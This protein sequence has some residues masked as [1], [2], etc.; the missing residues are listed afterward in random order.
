MLVEGAGY[1]IIDNNPNVLQ[2]V[3]WLPHLFTLLSGTTT[4]L[5]GGSPLI[6]KGAGFDLVRKEKNQVY[7]CGHRCEVD[8][9]SVTSTQLECKLPQINTAYV[10]DNAYGHLIGQR[11]TNAILFK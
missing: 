7:I 5:A 3:K 11:Y 9:S 1:A 4:T 6:V 8:L 10:V 2:S